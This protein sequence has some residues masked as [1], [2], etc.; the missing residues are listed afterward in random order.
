VALVEIPRFF[1]VKAG[2]PHTYIKTS[3][4]NSRNISVNSRSD[5]TKNL[6][7]EFAFLK[8]FGYNINKIGG[9]L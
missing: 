8:N 1:F 5:I 6:Q 9:I 4:V 7:K 2:F 3:N